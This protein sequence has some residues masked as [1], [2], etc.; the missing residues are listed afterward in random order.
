MYMNQLTTTKFSTAPPRK[1]YFSAK[2]GIEILQ[3][4]QTPVMKAGRPKPMEEFTQK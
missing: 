1:L 2:S 3:M 4:I